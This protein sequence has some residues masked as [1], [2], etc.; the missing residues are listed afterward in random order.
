MGVAVLTIGT[1]LSYIL[2]IS[3]GIILRQEEDSTDWMLP[4]NNNSWVELG[5]EEIRIVITSQCLARCSNWYII[6][7]RPI[8]VECVEVRK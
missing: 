1:R 5:S 6:G 8:S 4:T 3:A 2:P 7:E